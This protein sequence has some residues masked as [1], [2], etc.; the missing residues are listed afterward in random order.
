MRNWA[1]KG[2]VVACE[3]IRIKGGALFLLE[4]KDYTL[5]SHYEG[6][7]RL[8]LFASVCGESSFG[9]S[10]HGYDPSLLEGALREDEVI[11]RFMAGDGE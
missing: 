4:L 7:L 8:V 11:A 3:D 2:D 6:D 10:T 9:F 5:Y 1:I